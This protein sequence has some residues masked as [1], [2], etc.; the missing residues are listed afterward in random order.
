M[1]WLVEVEASADGV[2]QKL[3][4]LSSVL[5]LSSHDLEG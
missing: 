2:N 5:L 4:I 3:V 1:R